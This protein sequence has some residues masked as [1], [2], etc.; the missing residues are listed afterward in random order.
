MK[1]GRKA[2]SAAATALA[3]IWALAALGGTANAALPRDFF[4]VVPSGYDSSAEMQRMAA[5][6][7]SA[8]RV[9]VNWAR[10]EP[11][12]GVRDWSYYDSY[13]GAL[14]AADLQAQ[15]L[16]LGEPTW[17]PRFPRPPIYSSLARSSWQSFLTE[18][19]G[20]YGRDGLF[21]RQHP[22]LP[23]LPMVD[24]EVWNEPNLKGYWGGRPNPHQYVRLLRLSGAAVRRSDPQARIGIGGIFPPPRARYGVSL[25]TFMQGLYR[26]HGAR[27][28]F[29]A[30][31]IHPY[32]ARPKGVLAACRQ[33]RRIMNSHHDRATPMWITELGWSTGGVRWRQSPYRASEAGQ[34]KFLSRSYRRLIASRRQLG[35]ERVVW[36]TWQ[37][38]HPGTPWTLNMGLTHFD[39]SAK[40]SLAAYAQLPR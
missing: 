29:E 6:G 38:A 8:V 15:P 36:H 24:W 18:L 17:T 40:P 35:L 9:L 7:V 4:G 20:R 16:L 23:Y 37:D 22:N 13:V 11:N 34:A 5:N 31:S 30:L 19:A 14:A 25:K 12:Q 39:G 32:A 2:R 21:W 3:T 33:A 10:V 1:G 28:A 27:S 26:V